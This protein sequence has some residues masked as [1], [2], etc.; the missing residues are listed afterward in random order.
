MRRLV[1]QELSSGACFEV[2]ENSEGDLSVA[3]AEEEVRKRFESVRFLG[4]EFRV[5]LRLSPGGTIERIFPP[6]AENR[7]AWE[8]IEKRLGLRIPDHVRRSLRER[9]YLTGATVRELVQG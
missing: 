8:A 9:F 1:L 4:E 6:V 5:V 2:L 3:V 7:Q